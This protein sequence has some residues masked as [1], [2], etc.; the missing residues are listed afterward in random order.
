MEICYLAC[1]YRTPSGFCGSTG[2][3]A[4]C[5]HRQR[6]PTNADRIRAMSDEELAE[7]IDGFLF[8]KQKLCAFEQEAN[9]GKYLCPGYDLEKK[10]MR[11]KICWLDWLRQES[12]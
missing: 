12:V 8:E 3:A 5:P 9:T 10:V 7:L 11:C 2:G 4:T 1:A 6:K